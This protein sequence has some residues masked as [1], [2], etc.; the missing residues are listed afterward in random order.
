MAE[1]VRAV[2]QPR[3]RTLDRLAR[4]LGPRGVEVY[5]VA[6]DDDRADVTA[7]LREV[8]VQFPIL[9]DRGGA[10]AAAARLPTLRLPTTLIVD[11]RGVIRFVHE[12]WTERVA[13]EQRRQ[14]E[15]LL[16]E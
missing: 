1:L 8:P 11:R 13:H 6:L 15:E 2:P 12:G 7:F 9:W 4:D 16:S 5:G 10:N 3:S 14:V